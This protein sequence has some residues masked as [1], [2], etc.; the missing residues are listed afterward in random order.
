MVFEISYCES[1]IALLRLWANFFL[2]FMLKLTKEFKKKEIQ[3]KIPNFAQYSPNFGHPSSRKREKRDG[4][5]FF[6]V[7]IKENNL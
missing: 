1:L 3:L 7:F 4:I 6:Y 5:K 2:N